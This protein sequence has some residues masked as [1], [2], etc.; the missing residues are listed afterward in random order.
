MTRDDEPETVWEDRADAIGTVVTLAFVAHVGIAGFMTIP[1][2]EGES[3]TPFLAAFE[4]IAPYVWGI[5]AV[6]LAAAIVYYS[7]TLS[8]RY[9]FTTAGDDIRG[10]LDR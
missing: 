1:P 2:S 4:I 6:L 3:G 5:P 9:L 8:C 10:W 7:T